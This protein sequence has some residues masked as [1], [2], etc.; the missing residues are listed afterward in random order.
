MPSEELFANLKEVM[1]LKGG[2]FRPAEYRL[3][4]YHV[5]PEL[6]DIETFVRA[7]L[8]SMLEQ[9]ESQLS[10]VSP[11]MVDQMIGPPGTPFRDAVSKSFVAAGMLTSKRTTVEP[12][13]TP[14]YEF[15]FD[16]TQNYAYELHAELCALRNASARRLDGLP[17][18]LIKHRSLAEESIVRSLLEPSSDRF[19]YLADAESSLM[20]V[21]EQPAGSK[22]AIAWLMFGWLKMR[23]DG[24]KEEVQNAFSQASLFSSGGNDPITEESNRHLAHVLFERG[25]H[26]SAWMTLQKSLVVNKSPTMLFESSRYALFARKLEDATRN[27]D[28]ALRLWP[29]LGLS[30]ILDR[31]YLLNCRDWLACMEPFEAELRQNIVSGAKR[32]SDSKSRWMTIAQAGNPNFEMPASLSGEIENI[33]RVKGQED[34]FSMVWLKEQVDSIDESIAA[35]ALDSLEQ[36]VRQAKQG[37]INA[38]NAIE[39]LQEWRGR[40]LATLEA[41]CQQRHE[42]ERTRIAPGGLGRTESNRGCVLSMVSLAGG[43]SI[44]FLIC[45][46]FRGM[47][48]NIGPGTPAGKTIMIAL[49]IPF[50]VGVAMT[51]AESMKR[52]QM[53]TE[54]AKSAG[55]IND[56]VKAAVQKVNTEFQERMNDLSEQLDEAKANEQAAQQRLKQAQVQRL[57]SPLA[58]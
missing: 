40:S 27:F 15:L 52:W 43:Y 48:A 4:L 16:S 25:S 44:Y 36:D 19:E 49:L 37:V 11:S 26:E 34:L 35:Q 57:N 54:L 58:A 55:Q 39:A 24:G 18:R 22:D 13:L 23:K 28:E 53:E 1:H 12:E 5:A 3:A 21:L 29:L 7:Y 8:R 50:S 41:H 17:D 56:E 46:I 51:V 38:H 10:Q 42:A 45:A 9:T 2:L 20:E 32:L 31:D 30:C 33:K 14:I 6:R 47:V